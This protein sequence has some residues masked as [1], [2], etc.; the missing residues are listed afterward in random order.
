[1]GVLA[2][3]GAPNGGRSAPSTVLVT[4]ANGLVGSRLVARLAE[5][6]EQVVAVGRGP[7]RF[8]A[9]AAEYVEQDFLVPSSLGELIET[10]RPQAVLHAAAM[11]DVDACES[12]VL[13]A[14]TL[15]VSS[16]EAAAV[17]C[18]KI[19][20]RF[21]AL[22]TDYVFD[23]SS[24]PYG[25]DDAPNPRGVY[26]RTKRAGEEAALLLASDRAVCRVA[27]IYSGRKGVKRTFAVGALENLL[28]GREV[29]AFHDQ[30]VS[31]T[32][33]D[34]AAELVIGVLRSGEQG[35]FHCAGASAVSRVE[36]VQALARKA[37]ADER[38]VVP[39]AT[40]SVKLPAPRPLRVGLKVDKVQKL[41]GADVPLALDAQLDRFLAE[42]RA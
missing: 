5:A 36:F 27:V 25:E 22:S 4:G 18:R 15:N 20:A 3:Q 11:T 40:A 38:L 28:A 39:V 41:L 10:L 7:R 16:V 1:M 31:P 32:L 33:A 29:K 2:P 23:G 42:R 14:W 8:E 24:G 19:G 37:G 30:I 9:P 26:A 6:G 12:A 35:I 21:V 17:A 34:N 13:D